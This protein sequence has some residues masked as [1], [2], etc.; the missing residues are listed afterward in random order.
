MADRNLFWELKTR[1]PEVPDLVI[2]KYISTFGHDR[3][4]CLEMLTNESPKYLFDNQAGEVNDQLSGLNIGE[5]RPRSDSSGS[6]MSNASSSSAS[7]RPP[8]HSSHSLRN[9]PGYRGPIIGTDDCHPS[10]APVLPNEINQFMDYYQNE[11]NPNEIP[12]INCNNAGGMQSYS[13]SRMVSYGSYG[14]NPSGNP[15]A[16]SSQSVLRPIEVQHVQTSRETNALIQQPNYFEIRV[17]PSY[18]GSGHVTRVTQAQPVTQNRDWIQHPVH[19]N[20]PYQNVVYPS[21]QNPAFRPDLRSLPLSSNQYGENSSSTASSPYR[22]PE[23]EHI[24]FSQQQYESQHSSQATIYLQNPTANS[25]TFT[26]TDRPMHSPGQ[27]TNLQPSNEHGASQNVYRGAVV[28]NPQPSPKGITGPVVVE[29]KTPQRSGVQSHIQY[30][31]K[32][33]GTPNSNHGGANSQTVQNVMLGHV[34]PLNENSSESHQNFMSRHYTPERPTVINIQG[35]VTSRDEGGFMK[36][37]PMPNECRVPGHPHGTVQKS[38][39]VESNSVFSSELDYRC[40]PSQPFMSP[41]S[42]HSSLSSESSAA[43]ERPRSGSVQDDPA[44]LQALLSHQKSR[45][46]KLM[47]DLS[48]AEDKVDKLRSEVTNLESHVIEKK[49]QK[50]SVFPSS[51][52]LAKLRGEN[53]QLQADIQLMTRE[54]DLYNNGQTPLGV[55]DPLEQQNFYKNMNTG[56]RGSIYASTAQTPPRTYTSTVTTSV[57]TT[58]STPTRRPPE[59][60]PERPPRDPPPR[61][62]PPPLPPRIA[63]AS[64]VPPAPPRQPTVNSGDSDIDGEQWSCSACTFLNHPALNKCECCEMP[65]MNMTSSALSSRD[66]PDTFPSAGPNSQV[67]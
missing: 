63:A 11:Q 42:S 52:D 22:S 25:P 55:L 10:T 28:N 36:F 38:A 1:F 58:V 29:I 47:E 18:S 41:A 30:F 23:D 33:S 12:N 34:T 6:N 5:S 67:T 66:E 16:S 49:R 39:S 65:R 17:M 21:N 4:R 20:H 62:V 44:Y 40:V 48:V 57:T 45:M 56:Q 53:L 61:D 54:I 27:Y 9:V 14:L 15:S 37:P 24:N 8:Y 46:S 13:S 64:Q 50:S 31:N 35:Q 60:P 32:I 2:N 59:I 3:E 43:R 26:R 19:Y 7:S 51:V